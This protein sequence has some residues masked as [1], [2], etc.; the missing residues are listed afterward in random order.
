MEKL[1]LGGAGSVG[2]TTAVINVL[3]YLLQNG[4]TYSAGFASTTNQ[5]VRLVIEGHNSKG[6]FK[7]VIVNSGTDDYSLIARAGEIYH[8]HQD[9]H[10]FISSVRDAENVRDEFFRVMEFLPLDSDVL[11]IPLGKAR[12]GG[13]RPVAINWYQDNMLQ[14]VKHLLARDSFNLL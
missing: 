1:L 3:N 7:K 10:V 11:E 12:T 5:D 4:Y 2:K 9:A 14:L 13:R 8:A 6:E